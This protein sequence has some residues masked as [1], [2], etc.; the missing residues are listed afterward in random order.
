MSKGVSLSR[1][2]SDSPAGV[3]TTGGAAGGA[4]EERSGVQTAGTDRGLS[5]TGAADTAP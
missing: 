1:V 3:Q 2:V 4:G 5:K